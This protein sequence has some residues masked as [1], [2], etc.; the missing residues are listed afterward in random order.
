MRNRTPARSTPARR[1]Q[2]S[3]PALHA[4]S[5]PLLVWP[6]HVPADQVADLLMALC[7]LN[8]LRNAHVPWKNPPNFF[9]AARPNDGRAARCTASRPSRGLSIAAPASF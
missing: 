3:W 8:A 2:L 9:G 6:D 5:R 7:V 1:A 4:L